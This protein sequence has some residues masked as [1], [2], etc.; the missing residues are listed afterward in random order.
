MITALQ[1][2]I[3]SSPCDSD[4]RT[5]PNSMFSIAGPFGTCAKPASICGRICISS[6]G[7]EKYVS[8]RGGSCAGTAR[9]NSSW[10]CV[11]ISDP[12][13]A[14]PTVLPMDRK[15]I[16]DEVAAPIWLRGATFCTATV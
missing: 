3:R 7:F 1:K 10:Y 2:K 5:A 15:K 8:R 9:A 4:V 14:T 16:V 12:N 13:A 6:S 11:S